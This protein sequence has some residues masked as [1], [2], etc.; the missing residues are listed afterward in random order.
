MN[1]LTWP[2]PLIMLTS[3]GIGFGLFIAILGLVALFSKINGD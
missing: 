1:F 3:I 2:E